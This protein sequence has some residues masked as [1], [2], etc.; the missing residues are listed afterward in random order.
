MADVWHRQ[1]KAADLPAGGYELKVPC[2]ESA[3]RKRDIPRHD[4]HVE[5]AGPPALRAAV[6]ARPKQAAAAYAG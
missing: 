5:V 4:E 3:A 2:R 1:Q 6:T